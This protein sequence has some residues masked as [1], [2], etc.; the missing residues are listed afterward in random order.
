MD[1][2]SLSNLGARLLFPFTI[3]FPFR[4]FSSSSSCSFFVYIKKDEKIEEEEIG[5]R[6]WKEEKNIS[7]LWSSFFVKRKK[8]TKLLGPTDQRAPFGPLPTSNNKRA[9]ETKRHKAR[10]SREWNNKQSEEDDGPVRAFYKARRE[11]TR[12]YERK[13]NNNL[14][15]RMKIIQFIRRKREKRL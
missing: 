14:R 11:K 12:E 7:R 4:D 6:E 5:R 1:R 8:E 10:N 3:D 13:N 9:N 2:K 15:C